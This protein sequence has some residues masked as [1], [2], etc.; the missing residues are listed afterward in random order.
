MED[1]PIVDH[2]ALRPWLDR[3]EDGEPCV[4]TQSP[5]LMMERSGGSTGTSKLLPYTR[6]LLAEFSAA[7][8]PWMRDLAR[9]HPGVAKGRS[10]WS[11]SPVTHAN[12]RT[13]G[14]VP[15]GFEDD[16]DYFGP[17]ERWALRRMLAVPPE[18][19]R[20]RDVDAWRRATAERLIEARDLSF[21]SVWSPTFLDLL[22]DEVERIEGA[23][24]RRL[25]PQLAAV[26]CWMDGP[27]AHFIPALRARLPGVAF[28]GKGLLASEGVVTLPWGEGAPILAVASH[29]YEFLDV[30]AP[31]TSPLHPW[32]LREGG[33]YSPLLTTGAGLL[34][35][36]LK[37]VVRCAGFVGATPRLRFE[38]RLDQVADVCGEK[39]S[40]GQAEAALERA[41]EKTGARPRFAMLAPCLEPRPHYALFVEGVAHFEVAADVVDHALSAAHPYAHARRIGQLASVRVVPVTDARR[42]VE[43]H[44]V[45]RG[46]R[47]GSI[48][49]AALD[50]RTDWEDAFS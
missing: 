18:I 19:A 26:S 40:A 22:L 23:P 8:G 30:D 6:A 48:K 28:Q 3:V 35:Y 37:D 1:A 32:E 50:P 12:E 44:L 42:K 33:R 46:Q 39:V 31:A 14:G 13:R 43:R 34:R 15:V 11:L 38:G 20:I 49:P 47:L 29:V 27:S 7:T 10:Y 9:T 4:L 2:D 17:I 36:H 45:R 16:T 24:A 25:W 41:W 21:I 5:V